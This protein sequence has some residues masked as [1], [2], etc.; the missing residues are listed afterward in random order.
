M[1]AGAK[2]DGVTDDT[3]AIQAT[4]TACAN[5]GGGIVFFPPGIFPISATITIPRIG[6]TNRS[7]PIL[8]QGSGWM[9]DGFW[10]TGPFGTILA[11]K[12]LAGDMFTTPVH[13]TVFGFTS[14][15]SMTIWGNVGTYVQS[16]GHLLNLWSQPESWIRDVEIM[17]AFADGYHVEGSGAINSAT[18]SV[19]HCR[20]EKCGGYGIQFIGV[21]QALVHG[22][23]HL[24]AN[25]GGGIF[26]DAAS[27]QPAIIG[28]SFQNNSKRS[29]EC[30]A[31]QARI[32]G[33]DI[34][35]SGWAG[36]YV[37][38]PSVQIDNNTIRGCGVAG[39]TEPM[40]IRLFNA[41]E[42]IVSHNII[43][44]FN[45][46]QNWGISEEGTSDYN[47]IVNN[48]LRG[49]GTAAIKQLAGAHTVVRNNLGNNPEYATTQAFA[50]S[51]TPNLTLATTVIVTV[52]A[53]V[54]AVNLPT[55][56]FS[57]GQRM[58]LTVIQG[59]AGG[60][61]VAGWVAGYKQSWSDTGNTTGKRSSIS[62]IYDGTNWN[63]DG[64]QTPY[65]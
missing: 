35:L 7:Y 27:G 34:E 52:T 3:V 30:S 43:T 21:V 31:P 5:A 25:L 16:A 18:I 28:C 64:A 15:E 62:F 50:G 53:N 65:V 60:F 42:C 4:V 46:K 58:T 55:G 61:T 13:G 38:H 59:G 24:E 6:V 10:N 19:D 12:N 11:A 8:F 45:A 39:A 37:D 51:F 23:T 48:N 49:N 32:I 57:Q 1:A 40:G 56:V 44:D 33:N 47:M 26:L 63:Q 17:G 2:G 22:G 9:L 41:T 20:I 14:F 29:I 54:T 36:I